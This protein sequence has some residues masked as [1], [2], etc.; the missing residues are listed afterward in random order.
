[1][2]EVVTR[3]YA[4]GSY[5]QRHPEYARDSNPPHRFD[6]LPVELFLKTTD[7]KVVTGNQTIDL[8]DSLTVEDPLI[9]NPDGLI[10]SLRHPKRPPNQGEL[11]INVN[12][13]EVFGAFKPDKIREL[14]KDEDVVARAVLHTLLKGFIEPMCYYSRVAFLEVEQAF[15]RLGCSLIDWKIEFGFSTGLQM[16]IADVIDNDSWRLRDNNWDELSKENFRQNLPLNFV[17]EKY[18]LVTK[19]TDN[20]SA[21]MTTG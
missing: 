9:A 20:F 3:R 6:N 17:G 16:V 11:G 15:A 19:L 21:A 4:V 5:L 14:I 8:S 1:P 12:A 18:E 2:L 13:L 10:W 7:H